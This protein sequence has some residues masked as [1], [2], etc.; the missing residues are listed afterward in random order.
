M[1]NKKYIVYTISLDGVV[2]YVGKTVNFMDRKWNHLHGMN[3]KRYRRKS[4]IPEGTSPDLIDFSIL[5]TFDNEE[6]AVK[7]EQEYIEK[8]DTIKQGWNI[9]RSGFISKSDRALYKKNWAKENRERV[10]E[11]KHKWYIEHKKKLKS[12]DNNGI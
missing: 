4:A 6:S 9:R 12:I 2:M 5:E 8:Y 7:C 1:E 11:T 3:D 10:V